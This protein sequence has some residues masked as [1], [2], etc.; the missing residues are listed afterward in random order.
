MGFYHIAKKGNVPVSLGYL[1][2]KNK[3]AGIGGLISLSGDIDKD[4]EIIEDFYKDITAKYPELY[5]KK[6][7]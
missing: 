7:Y 4:M 6:I 5:N 1:D 3:I 2:Y